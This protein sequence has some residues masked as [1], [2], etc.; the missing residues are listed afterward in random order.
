MTRDEFINDVTTFSELMSFCCDNGCESVVED[1]RDND[2]YNEYLN[3]NFRDLIYEEGW[4]SA[5]DAMNDVDNDYYDYYRYDYGDWYPL[6]DD[7]DLDGFKDEV[8]EIMDEDDAWDD[9]DEEQ[10]E[11]YVEPEPA[12]EPEPCV[13]AEGTEEIDTTE[14]LALNSQLL[15]S[16]KEREVEDVEENNNDDEGVEE[17]TEEMQDFS[18]LFAAI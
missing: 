18:A 8:L 11:S 7:Y 17:E 13:P 4:Q 15:A 9:P 14:L 5:R 16:I 12:P 1:I 2:D 6:D 3:D 10:E